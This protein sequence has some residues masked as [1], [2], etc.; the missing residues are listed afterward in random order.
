VKAPTKSRPFFRID[1]FFL[2]PL[3][4]LE[5]SRTR[6]DSHWH[7][8]DTLQQSLHVYDWGN[9]GRRLLAVSISPFDP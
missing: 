4:K 8:T 9:S 6:P 1:I 2:V 3:S 5:G 7:E